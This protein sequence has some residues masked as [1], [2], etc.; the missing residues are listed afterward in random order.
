MLIALCLSGCSISSTDDLKGSGTQE[1]TSGSSQSSHSSGSSSQTSKQDFTGITFSGATFTYDGQA[2]SIYVSGAPSFATVTYTNNNK[3]SV[4]TYTVNAKITATNYN[5]LN[6]SATLR[7]L[8]QSITGVTF[9]NATFQYDGSAHSI[10]VSGTIPSGVSVSYSNNN[11]TESG[12]YTVTANL[13]GTG[14]EPLK[15]TA[16]LTIE[17]IPL[18]KSGYFYDKAFLYDGQNHSIVVDSAPSGVTITYK[19]TNT[20]GQNTFKN[21]GIYEIE[22]TVKSDNN[23]LTK[24]YATLTIFKEATASV[25][26]TKTPLTIDENLKWDQLHDALG[27]GNYTLQYLTGTYSVVNLDDPRPDNL[28]QESFSGHQSGHLFAT[29]GSDAFQDSYSLNEE[30]QNHTY[31]YYKEVGDDIIHLDSYYGSVTKFPKAAFK[32]TITDLNASDA[33]VALNKGGDGEFNAGID[34]DDYYSDTGIAIIEDGSFTVLMEH[35]RDTSDEGYNYK[36]F[37]KIYK[38]YNIG[39]T[40][41]DIPSDFIPSKEK[42]SSM[43]VDT[44]YLGGVKYSYDNFGSATVAKYYH[45]AQL[46]VNYHRAI[47]LEPGTYTVLPSFYDRVVKAITYTRSNYA[48]NTNQS[49]YNFRLMVNSSGAYQGEYSELGTLEKLTI[50]EFLSRGG[51]VEYYDEWHE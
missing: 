35:P 43:G 9:E 41:V 40:K 10:A 11:K 3:V 12:T 13:S 28:F 16:K 38:Y 30:T 4:G 48:Y 14:Y 19:C 6:L 20:T 46:Y 36:Y 22:A 8:G 37:Y 27:N 33:F 50:S 2:H 26:S 1:S 5:T 25:D 47:F 51:T 32:E 17:P 39:N 31:N 29:N 44:F 18:N 15:L 42:I 49:G 34:G 23:H 24:K 7:I 21:P 45:N